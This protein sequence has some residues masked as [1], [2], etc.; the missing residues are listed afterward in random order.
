M[1]RSAAPHLVSR[2]DLAGAAPLPAGLNRTTTESH[3]LRRLDS[4][5]VEAACD[6]G[7]RRPDEGDPKGP[8]SPAF[9][10]AVIVVEA[11]E[12]VGDVGDVDGEGVRP[13]PLGRLG[14]DARELHEALDERALL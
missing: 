8:R 10:H 4:D 9:E 1:P 13:A 6:H 3:A 12:V 2:C 7:L 11:V 5:E 14:D